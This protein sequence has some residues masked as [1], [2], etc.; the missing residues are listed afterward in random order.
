MPRA[1]AGLSLLLWVIS[2]SAA[3]AEGPEIQRT[4]ALDARGAVSIETFKGA[5]D[6]QTWD[7]SRAEISAR[8]EPDTGCGNNAQQMERVRLTKVDIDSTPARLSIRSNYDALKG[9]DRIPMEIKGMNMECNAH[10]FVLYRLRIPRT[11]RLDIADHKS[12]I[13]VGGLQADARIA[14]HKG[15]VFVKEHDGGLDFRTHKG[16]AHVEFARLA[17]SRLET[18]KGD[19][20]VAV[21]RAAGFDLDARVERRG[22]LETPFTL[23]ETQVSRRA[24]IYEQ[25]INGGGPLLELSTHNGRLRITEK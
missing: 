6:V 3:R 7:E 23:D 8:I 15:S 1:F 13:T 24:R 2:A 18:Y 25:K 21:P 20:E 11:A 5:I 12:K 22:L 17:E 16:D 10:P 4:V 9:L 14:S 19:I